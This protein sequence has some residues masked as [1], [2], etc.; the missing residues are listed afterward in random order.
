[1]PHRDCARCQE[2]ADLVGEL[3]GALVEKQESDAHVA[4]ALL[5]IQRHTA[6][7]GC[8]VDRATTG[9]TGM[10]PNGRKR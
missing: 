10:E 6:G 9:L 4:R 7:I 8:A 1:M 5:E 2:L 3:Q